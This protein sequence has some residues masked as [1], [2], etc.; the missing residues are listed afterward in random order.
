[1][2]DKIVKIGF[3]TLRENI[4][5]DSMDENFLLFDNFSE[6][7]QM[8]EWMS[9]MDYP[10]RLNRMTMIAF[11]LKGYMKFNLGLKKMLMSEN[12]IYVILPD[13]IIQ[14]TEIS[15]DFQVGI[16][17]VIRDFFNSQNH[18]IETINLHNRLME[19]SHFNLSEREIQEYVQIFKMMK[20]KYAD[21]QHHYRMQ[22]IQNYFQ[23]TFYNLY[24]LIINQQKVAEKSMLNNNMAQAIAINRGKIK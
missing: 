16:T 17:V 7:S 6:G 10:V 19:Q 18:F 12:Q 14:T 11:C 1:M 22:I 3:H 9:D 23:I 21:K 24:N 15:P 20:E 2:S 5:N 4:E 8:V 13:Q